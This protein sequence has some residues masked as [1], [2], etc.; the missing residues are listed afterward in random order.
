MNKMFVFA[1]SFNG[2]ISKWDVSGVTN[3]EEMFDSAS[4]FN[5]DISR[6]DVFSVINMHGM[7]MEAKSFAQ[8]LC[9]AWTT[10]TATYMCFL[11]VDNTVCV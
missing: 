4:S 10:S 1:S 11:R 2:D 6:W 8:T 7:F 5:G 9:G 3:M